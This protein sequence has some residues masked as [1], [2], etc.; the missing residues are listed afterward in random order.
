MVD[1]GI[2]QSTAQ[3]TPSW[4]TEALLADGAIGGNTAVS[5][6]EA[7]TVGEGVGF[8]G[9]LARLHLHYNGNAESAPRTIIAKFPSQAEGARA[10]GNL[11]GVY[12]REVRFYAEIGD[13]VG[14]TTPHCYHSAMDVE[15]D[16]YLL[17]LEDLAASGR[18]G[19]QVAGC[20]EEE[21]LLAVRELATFH[22]IRWDSPKLHEI[23]WL[24]RGSDLVRA[25]MQ[26]LY[27][28]ASKAFM[29]EFGERLTAE[30]AT[31]MA[32]LDQRIL[33]SLPELETRPETVIHADYRLDNMFFGAAG[34]P[35]E[36]AVF[37]WQVTN[38]S[39]GPY[40]LAY[41]VS[42]CMAPEPRRACERRLIQA[43]HDVLL[44]RGVRDY[45][46]DELMEDYRRSLVL[47]LA[48]MTVSGATLE[49]TNDRAVKL[50]EGLLDGLVT[51]I[52]DHNALDLLPAAP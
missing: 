14:L 43:Y 36:L 20:S 9:L 40:D 49:R 12:E 38:R 34:A 24:P 29:E 19:D 39:N 50:W 16:Q 22:A 37:D 46:F 27:P 45:P 18:V 30:I 25:S 8:I 47:A 2:P 23:T 28:Q 42:G 31:E 6:F 3:L 41:F 33:A 48:I 13:D 17:L 21:A 11:Y 52:T 1:E 4:L 10:I 51:S 26:A 44:E 5:S 7:E 35:Y 32:T 15:S